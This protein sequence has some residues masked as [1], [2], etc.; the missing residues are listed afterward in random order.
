MWYYSYKAQNPIIKKEQK[1]NEKTS[2][3]YFV[4]HEQLKALQK[5]KKQVDKHTSSLLNN[6][7]L[8]KRRT[9]DNV[10]GAGGAERS[11]HPIFK[12]EIM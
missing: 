12:K 3:Q 11:P 7:K 9:L 1:K 2:K 8:G 10:V 5:N 4:Y 6:N